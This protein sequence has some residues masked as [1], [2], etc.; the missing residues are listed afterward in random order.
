MRVELSTVRH[1]GISPQLD[2]RLVRRWLKGLFRGA[3]EL[4]YWK[5]SMTK[6]AVA[7]SVRDLMVEQLSSNKVVG[8]TQA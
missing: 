7:T 5:R 2:V 4:S 3:M 1:S 6:P 8:E